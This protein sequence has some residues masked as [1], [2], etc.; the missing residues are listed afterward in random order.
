MKKTITI[1][2][3]V[4]MLLS[5]AA[6]GNESLSD[7]T[8]A[9]TTTAITTTDMTESQTTIEETTSEQK[10]EPTTTSELIT[11]TQAPSKALGEVYTLGHLPDGYY[12]EQQLLSENGISILWICKENTEIR[13]TQK[14]LS[15]ALAIDEKWNSFSHGDMQIFEMN[16]NDAGTYCW[17]TEKYAFELSVSAAF[18][19]EEIVT[20]IDSMKVKHIFDFEIPIPYNRRYH[21]YACVSCESC[22]AKVFYQHANIAK[23]SKWWCQICEHYQ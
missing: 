19:Q 4:M 13:F 12:F 21:Y 22:D 11:S 14:L 10:T 3:S 1:V 8:S 2:L 9:D 23:Q 5:F 6:C 15:N 7:T 20:M 16:S 17:H 18:T